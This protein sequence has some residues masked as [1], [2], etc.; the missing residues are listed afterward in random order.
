MPNPVSSFTK[1]TQPRSFRSVVLRPGH[2][3]SALNDLF[4]LDVIPADYGVAGTSVRDEDLRV[5]SHRGFREAIYDYRP[6][7]EDESI[8]A[9]PRPYDYGLLGTI[10]LKIEDVTETT[11][12]LRTAFDALVEEW[13]ERTRFACSVLEMATDPAYQRII[14]LGP[15]VTPLILKRLAG[16]PDHWFWALKAITGDDPVPEEARGN[17]SKMSKA[18]L[19]WGRER[20]YEY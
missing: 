8:G 1:Q 16:E 17:L 15:Q 19:E 4:Y 7:L 3:R 5:F 10:S 13:Q 18:W 12:V 6:N 11:G 20:G 14:G 9:L 2:K